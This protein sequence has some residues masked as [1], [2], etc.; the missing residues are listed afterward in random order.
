MNPDRRTYLTLVTSVCLCGVA[1]PAYATASPSAAAKDVFIGNYGEVIRY[2]TTLGVS[3]KMHRDMEV[4]D[5]YRKSEVRDGAR[6][7]RPSLRTFSEEEVAQLIITPRDTSKF[8][9]L[10][11]LRVAKI[12]EMEKS[13][14]RYRLEAEPALIQVPGLE[15]FAITLGNPPMAT[16]FYADTPR[17]RCILTMRPR[18]AGSAYDRDF[19]DVLASLA[20]F[21][22]SNR[23]QEKVPSES[24][25]P[26]ETRAN[27]TPRSHAALKIIILAGLLIAGVESLR[28]IH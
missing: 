25:P 12:A 24:K 2:S 9:A 3:A 16:Q 4:V 17:L 5:F 13:Q 21:L 28:R 8:R 18:V 26:T 19:G 27:M 1:A 11:D 20:T 6:R 23:R 15:S 10:A 14:T 22:A 7:S